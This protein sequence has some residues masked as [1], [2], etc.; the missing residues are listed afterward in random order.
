[1]PIFYSIGDEAE[2]Q[3]FRTLVRANGVGPKLTL[4]IL[5]AMELEIFVDFGVQRNDLANQL[6]FRQKL[7][8][9]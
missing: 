4:N 5:S 9:V 7:R 3:T 8:N 1:M 6:K 2:R